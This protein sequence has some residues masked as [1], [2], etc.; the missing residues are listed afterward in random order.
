MAADDRTPSAVKALKQ[1]LE[2][3]E[4]EKRELL[5]E[6]ARLQ[7]T[8]DVADAKAPLEA[9]TSVTAASACQGQALQITVSRPR[10]CV[11]TA[12][13]ERELGQVRLLSCLPQRVGAG[14]LREA[15]SEVR[16]MPASCV[17]RGIG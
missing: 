4:S 1:R 14:H 5:T 11:P 15:A 13:A 10:R 17:R 16:R 6:L 12:V 9:T 7:T 3:L 2:A 8:N